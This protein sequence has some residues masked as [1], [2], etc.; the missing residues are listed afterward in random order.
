MQDV[1]F[2]GDGFTVRRAVVGTLENNVYLVEDTTSGEA[3]L[4]D[5]ADDPGAI[6]EFVAETPVIGVF[7]T[8]GHWDHHQAVPVVPV[9]LGA[10]FLLHP[11]DV[12][13]AGKTA[14]VAIA[15]GPFSVGRTHAKVLHTPG[16]TPGSVCLSVPGAVFTGDTLFPGGPGAT[17]FDHSSFTTIIESIEQELFT[18]PDETVVFPGHGAA[19][20][21]GTE[22]PHLASWIE[23]GW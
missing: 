8:H 6:A 1:V 23:R 7:T 11:L 5:A 22:R 19:T 18:L 4:I 15:P 13:I 9:A 21:I 2:D 20:T 14:D 3:L 17:R 10:P 16:H 12:T